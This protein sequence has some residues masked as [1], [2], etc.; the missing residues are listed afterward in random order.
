MFG[1]TCPGPVVSS[2]TKQDHLPND[3]A[4]VNLKTPDSDLIVVNWLLSFPHCCHPLLPHEH[5][6]PPGPRVLKLDA[7]AL[8]VESIETLVREFITGWE[9]AL[10]GLQ[11][12]E[13]ASRWS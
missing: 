6:K 12:I 9:R 4:L 2:R 5:T 10:P 11:L 1:M 7:T 3:G 8:D 13:G